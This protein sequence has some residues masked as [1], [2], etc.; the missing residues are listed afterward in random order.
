M[1]KIILFSLLIGLFVSSGVLASSNWQSNQPTFDNLYSGDLEN[2]WP[3]LNDMK[4]D[5]CNAT[6]DFVIGIPPGGCSPMVV[7]SDLL[8]EQ[9]V[10][11]F[12]QL[13]AIKVNPLIKVSSIKSISFK[14]D[15]P[16]GVRSVVYHPARAAVKSYNT[17]LGDP[18]LENIGYVVII[19]KQEKV[20][21]NM[22]EWI[23]G[24]LTAKM[25]Y[26]AEEAYGTGQGE[27]Y[28]EQMGEDEWGRKYIESSFWKGRGFLRVLDIEDGSAK[29]QVM[30]D[31]NKVL[32]TL[33][34]KEG[35]TS[36]SSYLPG[37]YCKAGLKVKLTE[38]TTQE[39]MARLNVGGDDIWVREGG[40]FLNGKCSVKSLDVRSNNDGEISIS[41][42]GAGKIDPLVLSGNGGLFEVK[43][44]GEDRRVK[45][46]KKLGEAVDV[47]LYLAYLG[48]YPKGFDS[49][50][51]E[52]A[53]L[54]EGKNIK[55]TGAFYAE[56]DKLKDKSG[57]KDEFS[58]KLEV[59]LTAEKL[60][61]HFVVEKDEDEN[62][63]V[64]LGIDDA[65]EDKET[66]NDYFDKSVRVVKSELVADYG[67][68]EK[69]IGGTW[70]EDALYEEIVLAREVGNFSAQ[71][72]LMDLFLEE[73]PLAKTVDYV[74]DMRAKLDGT[75]YSKSYVSVY[76]GNE[77]KSISVVDFKPF[78]EGGRRVDLKIGNVAKNNLSE[79]G[80]D[81]F[82]NGEDGNGVELNEDSKVE[83]KEILPGSAKLYFYSSNK[84]VSK[85]TIEIKEGDS[86]VFDGIEVHV[87]ETRVKEV[88]HVS[89]IPDVEHE[90]S[91]ADFTFKIGVE[92]RAIE[93]SP[94]KTK[95]MIANLNKSIAKWEDTVEKLG[96]V[97]TGLK[98]ACFATSTV[99]MVKSMV[100]GTNGAALARTEIMKEYKKIC[101][102]KYKDKTR[103]QCYNDLSDQIDADVK[104]MTGVLAGVNERMEAIQEKHTDN[105]GGIF[106]GK[107]IKDSKKYNEEL[108]LETGEGKIKVNVGG[109]EKEVELGKLSTSQVQAVLTLQDAEKSK[110]VN[111]IASAQAKVDD[112]L[113]NVALI[114]EED[115]KRFDLEKDFI[116]KLC[117]DAGENCKQTQIP[118]SVVSKEHP[119]FR[120]ERM[121]LTYSQFS[122][123]I[124]ARKSL[125]SPEVDKNWF[126]SFDEP[127]ENELMGIQILHSGSSNYLYLFDKSLTQLGIYEAKA[128][129]GEL[130]IKS[131]RLNRV[132]WKEEGFD[133]RAV[134]S[135][136]CSN[137]WQEGTAEVSYYES[138]DNKGLPA[139]I[140]FDLESG[141]YVSVSNSGG[142]WADDSVQ[143]YTASGDVKHSM[144]CNVGINGRMENGGGDDVCSSFNINTLGGVDKFGGCPSVDVD[145]L[146]GC[147]REA[148]QQASQ[149]S[150]QSSIMI[151]ACMNNKDITLKKGKPKSQVGG[152]EC[153]D[154][155]SPTDCKLMFNVCDP[156]I[157]PPSRCDFGGKFPVSDV[158]QTGVIGGLLLCL[159]NSKEDILMPVCLSGIHAGLDTY[160]SILKSERE[161]LEKSLET[162]ELVGICDQ[163][164][165]I[166]KCEFFWGQM[167]PLMDQLIP[168]VIEYAI[169]GDRVR[170]GGEY[171]FVSHSWNTMKQG[172]SYFKNTY[173]QNAF[174]AFNIRSTQEIGS[175]VCK[176]FIGSSV[177][178]SANF[179]E[180]LLA[181]ESPSQFYAQ[182][183][184]VTFTE[185]TV[186]ATSQYK[187]YYHIYAGNDQGIQYKVYLKNP[188]AS[189][190]Y[191]STPEIAVKSGYIA[192][193]S[194]ADESID[195]TAPAGYKELCVVVNAKEECG[196]KQVTTSFG[197][198][199]LAKKYSEDQ[200]TEEDIKTEKECISGS[201][202]AISMA[203]LNLQAGAEEMLN[204]EIALR[205]IVRICAS[206]NPDTGIVKGD[207]VGCNEESDCAKGFE[208]DG[209]YCKSKSEDD[210]MQNSGSAWKDVGYCGDVNLRCWL[211]VNSVKDDLETVS[212]FEGT[213]FDEL[214]RL[215]GLID[216]TRFSLEKVAQ[217]LDDARVNIEKL[218]ISRSEVDG[219]AIVAELDNIIGRDNASGAGT[220]GDRAEALALKASVWR[221]LAGLGVEDG[222]EGPVE[223]ARDPAVDAIVNNNAEDVSCAAYCNGAGYDDS[224]AGVE[225]E[226]CADGGKFNSEVEEGCCCSGKVAVDKD[227][228]GGDEEDAGDIS[229]S[230]EDL[231]KLMTD[232]NGC[233]CGDKCKEYAES[234][235]EYS[236]KHGID[237]AKRVLAIMI[238]E[239]ECVYSKIGD[240]GVSFGLMQITGTSFEEICKDKFTSS[241]YG[242]FLNM[243][244][245]PS[246]ADENIEC[247]VM[248]LKKKYD[249]YNG[250]VK[251]SWAWDTISDKGGFS[252]AVRKCVDSSH[253]YYGN[254]LDWEAAERGYNGW[255]CGSGV[256]VKYVENVEDILKK[257]KDESVKTSADIAI[258]NDDGATKIPVAVKI[259]DKNNVVEYREDKESFETKIALDRE[260][261]HPILICDWN[262]LCSSVE[263]SVETDKEKLYQDVA[264][265]VSWTEAVEVVRKYEEDFEDEED[266][267]VDFYYEAD[268]EKDKREI[269][270]IDPGH[271]GRDSGQSISGVYEKDLALAI[272]KRLK[273]DFVN[274]YNTFL[275]REDDF[276][277]NLE[278][279]NKFVNDFSAD[280]FLSV[281]SD[282]SYDE[283]F[284][285]LFI[286]FYCYCDSEREGDGLVQPCAPSHCVRDSK[287]EES[288]TFIESLVRKFEEDGFDV[289]VKGGDFGVLKNLDIPAAL[290]E[291]GFLTNAEDLNKL[292]EYGNY[293][294]D[295]SDD[296][297]EEKFGD[298]SDYKSIS[299]ILD[300]GGSRKDSVDL[301]KRASYLNLPLTF[302]VMP[303]CPYIGETV[304]EIVKY[305]NFEVM[306]HQPMEPVGGASPEC[307]D[308]VV[309]KKGIYTDSTNV[310]GIL[311][312]NINEIKSYLNNEKSKFVGVNNHMGSLVTQD[313]N[314]METIGKSLRSQD[315]IFVDSLTHAKSVAYEVIKNQG[316][317]TAR[318]D[319]FIDT[320]NFVLSSELKKI[321]ASLLAGDARYKIAIG[322]FNLATVEDLKIFLDSNDYVRYGDDY[323]N[324]EN[325]IKFSLLSEIGISA[326]DIVVKEKSVVV[327]EVVPE[328]I[329]VSSDDIY[330]VL[331]ANKHKMVKPN[332][333]SDVRE[334]TNSIYKYMESSGIEITP[335]SVSVVLSILEQESAFNANP[336]VDLGEVCFN[337]PKK[338][339]AGICYTGIKQCEYIFGKSSGSLTGKE[340]AQDLLNAKDGNIKGGNWFVRQAWKVFGPGV[341]TS[342]EVSMGPAQL[343]SFRV[344]EILAEARGV[345]LEDVELSDAVFNEI[346]TRD[347]GLKYGIEYLSGIFETYDNDFD[348][349]INFMFADYNAGIYSSRNAELQYELYRLANGVEPSS[350][351]V[352]GDFLIWDAPHESNSKKSETQKLV[353][354]YF[355]REGYDTSGIRD[356]LEQEKT[357]EFEGTDVF[358]KIKDDYGEDAKDGRIPSASIFSIKSGL[359]LSASSYV[360]RINGKHSAYC[361]S[362]EKI[363]KSC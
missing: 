86:Y 346:F 45:V 111:A 4:N 75:D 129:G 331:K 255:G 208:C 122:E 296:F 64:F 179:I 317:K 174:K 339:A 15:Y 203:Q 19:L 283:T 237:D 25:T 73:Y 219:L 217:I 33:T 338:C 356:D 359:T 137:K 123:I 184:E 146:Y 293:F 54:V 321:E 307:R 148:I 79:I 22:S 222:A 187:V 83:V 18:T 142:T 128:D 38:I 43:V 31:E 78:S 197:V 181:P 340:F 136:D 336:N 59:W 44:T 216:S 258:S 53:I 98:G 168:G 124:E 198:D 29:V 173:A 63:V 87:K 36:S 294:P 27:Y 231:L 212:A 60:G 238:Q 316:V 48:K 342:V 322:H 5:Q 264:D 286:Y 302:A 113:R 172:V 88:A 210:V 243:R 81:D 105:S 84:K 39:D 180:S 51:S 176:G 8:A 158:I 74:R 330:E 252:S 314:I 276:F 358:I 118:F 202:S 267:E 65:L 85:K 14:G 35:E 236:E 192:A 254:Y 337:L 41:C 195:F 11:V 185:A 167:A 6:T 297:E 244:I 352:D 100:D 57:T 226:K 138:G 329:Y 232:G 52:I 109:D 170:G 225:K 46:K 32:R 169:S 108:N 253:P 62:G 135:G 67:S 104:A 72:D 82:D 153:Q 7:R 288:K 13:Y 200:A 357:V 157:C 333:N 155:M 191:A 319:V 40:K 292:K 189:S 313:S 12:C 37:F 16:E 119:N 220:N 248:V 95:R 318:R 215:K 349:N 141:W 66:N 265:S 92:K 70:A 194:S 261:P 341:L 154:F 324:V 260:G 362:F 270:V 344:R 213:S 116:F 309:D 20:E 327:P 351:F 204:P 245:N 272:S 177:P 263:D 361:A 132:P 101:D 257:L 228:D 343:K 348:E 190:Y 121:W 205:G 287:Y 281:H 47:G 278:D 152:F 97:V 306:L 266:F 90:S 308:D 10:P 56:I 269:L 323:I 303:G 115:E 166:Y 80:S 114:Q 320:S 353:K 26:D 355:E 163:V 183:N 143:G 360:D 68:E 150:D 102:T 250:G 193:G 242:D 229:V 214:D 310:D 188:P 76:V 280:Y 274:D 305:D 206:R 186:P 69:E 61:G 347:G 107:S 251:S 140:P 42:N 9:N 23:A 162:G 94:E 363:G 295:V 247:G 156:V 326:G 182:F 262:Y 350:N 3:I 49:S 235:V 125:E 304:E 289:S 284:S 311:S 275:T 315:L 144:I 34:L 328:V 139:V 127:D 259:T 30:Q 199:Y 133:V 298:I 110:N 17:L 230:A 126:A 218:T 312:E 134:D 207:L 273:E 299:V 268:S 196:F 89:L 211:D 345:N 209:N 224:A 159:P 332:Q 171:A 24:N 249:D 301:I 151:R 2:Y 1:K 149:Q 130:I 221:L 131:E 285:G 354:K 55:G 227:D 93:L 112:A 256:N 325:K 271:G 223:E 178:G 96:D 175:S 300:D 50:E 28:L 246:R 201:P 160:T 164:T 161:C 106:G 21:A 240:D 58:K 77:F 290:V 282:S 165:S 239:S 120:N 103:T 241:Y 234:I 335:S 117:D 99:L 277:I 71:K 147:A 279:R 145:K 91:E 291:M 233:Y 334:W